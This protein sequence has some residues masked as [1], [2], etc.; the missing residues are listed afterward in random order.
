MPRQATEENKTKKKAR[1]CDEP[2]RV[3]DNF[4]LL[5]A[6]KWSQITF[7]ILTNILNSISERY[8]PNFEQIDISLTVS[9]ITSKLWW[10]A[11]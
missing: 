11:Y 1:R 7:C 5:E 4:S 6:S 10:L 9:A 3:L 2:I 8:G